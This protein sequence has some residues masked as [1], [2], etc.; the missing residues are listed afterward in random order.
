MVTILIQENQTNCSVIQFKPFSDDDGLP[1]PLNQPLEVKLII[2][3][4]LLLDLL[5]GLKI[6]RSLFRYLQ[7][8][9][10]K[11]NPINYFLWLEQIHSIFMGLNI[12]FTLV[13]FLVPFPISNIIGYELCNWAD[14]FGSIYMISSPTW[15]CII[16][17]LRKIISSV[18]QNNLSSQQGFEQLWLANANTISRWYSMYP[19]GKQKFNW[20]KPF[21]VNGRKINNRCLFDN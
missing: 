3:C 8:T 5:V 11:Q 7:S 1:V 18:L 12:T 14:L 20:S 19:N 4:L 15:N 2:S 13:V 17:V 16:A 9:D 10:C 6:R 21:C